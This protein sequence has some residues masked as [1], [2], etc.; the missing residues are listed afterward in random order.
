MKILLTGSS[1]PLGR[2]VSAALGGEHRL[3]RLVGPARMPRDPSECAVDIT[4]ADAVAR[5]IERERPDA[6]VHLAAITGTAAESDAHLTHLVN[7]EATYALGMCAAQSGVRRLVFA[8]SA[9][10]YGVGYDRP[11]SE[12]DA[13]AARSLYART[14][15]QAEGALDEVR[16]SDGLPSLALRIFNLYG[17]GFD[18]SLIQRVR[19]RS[20]AEK[21]TLAGLDNFVRDYVE[22]ADVVAAIKTALH[23]DPPASGVVNIGSGV[24]TS[25]RRIVELFGLRLGEDFEVHPGAASYSVANISRARRLLAFSPRPLSERVAEEV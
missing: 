20:A 8:S 2:A 18:S 6:V 1:S 9:A 11:V 3:V 24:P 10:V 5:I 19:F 22:V 4:D 17:P 14:K 21:L 25:N 23:V 13:P 15:L 7:V 16:R 12:D